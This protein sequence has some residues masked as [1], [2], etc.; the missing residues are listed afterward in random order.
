MPEV[1]DINGFISKFQGAGARPSLYEVKIT[2]KSSDIFPETQA[3]PY[4]CKNAQLPAS[5]VGEIQV[6]F[7]G[8]QVKLPGTR[9][10][11]ALTLT[12]YNDEDFLIRDRMER[13][14]KN[15]GS[16]QKAFG[17]AV[18]I[19]NDPQDKN[20]ADTIITVSQ[21]G[22]KQGDILRTYE[23]HHAFPTS[24]A[25][26]D[27]G[28]DQGETIEEFAVTFAYSFFQ[29]PYASGLGPM[30]ETKTSGGGEGPNA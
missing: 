5:T 19:A 8:R 3:I 27:L 26:I 17:N 18:G 12:F 4:L 14:M 30:V 21:L 15:I 25:A 22:K 28:F 1:Q 13:W 23:F 24:I 10:Y 2:A 6:N 11:E 9:T 16:F 29:I 7:L 20:A